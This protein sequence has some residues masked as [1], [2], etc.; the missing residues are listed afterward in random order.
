MAVDPFFLVK[1]I[2]CFKEVSVDLAQPEWWNDVDPIYTRLLSGVLTSHQ[3]PTTQPAVI[4]MRDSPRATETANEIVV[5]RGDGTALGHPDSFRGR[6]GR[7]TPS[8]TSKFGLLFRL[9]GCKPEEND[10]CSISPAENR[11]VVTAAGTT[12]KFERQYHLAERRSAP[13]QARRRPPTRNN[14][15]PDGKHNT[16]PQAY[17]RIKVTPSPGTDTCF[18]HFTVP[19]ASEIQKHPSK[20]EETAPRLPIMRPPGSAGL[21][22]IRKGPGVSMTHSGIQRY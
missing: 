15:P 22:K 2:G 13:Q 8:D 7:C 5:D 6:A 9:C 14:R 3:S 4:D 18:P 12:Y 19:R 20:P 1:A 16:R 17:S 10:P 21:P 11:N